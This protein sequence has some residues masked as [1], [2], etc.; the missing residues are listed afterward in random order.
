MELAHRRPVVHGIERSDLVNSHGGHLQD[1]RHLVH[2]ADAGEAVLALAQVQDRHHGG[3][4][5]LG[6][7]ALQDLGDNGLVLGGEL[8]GQA[9]VVIGGVAVLKASEEKQLVSIGPN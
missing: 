9:R 2:D 6:R 4:F 7:V 5:V 3:L 8:E 1:A